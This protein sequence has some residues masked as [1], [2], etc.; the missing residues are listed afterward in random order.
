[1]IGFV[2]FMHGNKYYGVLDQNLIKIESTMLSVR[3]YIGSILEDDYAI[4]RLDG[5]KTCKPSN[6]VLVAYR[7]SVR[8]QCRRLEMRTTIII[9]V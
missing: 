7:L 5:I 8:T 2:L 3:Q 1:M 4:L 6:A 9:T